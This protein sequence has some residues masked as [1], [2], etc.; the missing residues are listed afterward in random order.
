MTAPVNLQL[1]APYAWSGAAARTTGSPSC[2]AGTSSTR[3]A[4]SGGCGPAAAAPIAGP[5]W[6]APNSRMQK[7]NEN[8]HE[9][10]GADYRTSHVPSKL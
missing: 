2:A 1:S 9:S 10:N 8:D 4:W 3:R 7:L 5:L 6:P